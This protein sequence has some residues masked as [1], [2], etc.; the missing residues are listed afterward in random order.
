MNMRNMIKQYIDVDSV[1]KN[2]E[3][4]R[5]YERLRKTG[6][7]FLLFN[8]TCLFGFMFY[9]VLADFTVSSFL[10]GYFMQYF[11]NLTGYIKDIV[12]HNQH[13]IRTVVEQQFGSWVDTIKLGVSYINE[14]LNNNSNTEVR[15]QSHLSSAHVSI[16]ASASASASTSA[17]EHTE[18]SDSPVRHSNPVTISLS[19]SSMSVKSSETEEES[20][21]TV[22]TNIVLNTQP[23]EIKTPTIQLDASVIEY[24]LKRN[25]AQDALMKN[26][27]K[28][29]DSIIEPNEQ[30]SPSLSSISDESD[31]LEI[32]ETKESHT[33]D[34]FEMDDTIGDNDADDENESD[35]AY[36]N[37]L[38]SPHEHSSSNESESESDNHHSDDIRKQ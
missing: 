31:E 36:D 7:F 20:P 34:L 9:R 3:F 14:C 21:A 4:V 35:N 18:I 11:C 1:L 33:D 24:L 17:N 27:M 19:A 8:I 37:E 25:Q 22:E 13:V 29:S 5:W 26:V 23:I 15:P 38:Q 16:S 28:L 12:V 2:E 6:F 32:S 30:T 10:F